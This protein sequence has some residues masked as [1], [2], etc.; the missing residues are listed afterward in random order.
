MLVYRAAMPLIR[1]A[2]F[3]AFLVL[4]TGTAIAAMRRGRAPLLER[5][6]LIYFFALTLAAGI[7][8]KDLWPFSGYPILAES[9]SRWREA[10]WYS[11]AGVDSRGNEVALPAETWS[12]LMPSVMEK[13]LERTFSALPEERKRRAA[14]WI[15]ARANRPPER[16][17][18]VLLGP[19][20][21]PDWLVRVEAPPPPRLTAVRVYRHT[22]EARALAYEY[23]P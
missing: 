15:L 1:L 11:A 5:A 14:Q 3:L 8:Q 9:S 19:L 6:L 17:N 21:A 20:T 4:G 18:D 2:L 7:A 10:V 13:W 23:A 16:G 22:I 12:P